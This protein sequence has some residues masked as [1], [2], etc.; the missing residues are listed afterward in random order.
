MKTRYILPVILLSVLISCQTEVEYTGEITEPKLVVFARTDISSAVQSHICYVQHS[1]FFLEDEPVEGSFL[2]DA[3]VEWQLNDGAFHPFAFV[4]D[5]CAYLPS[6]SLPGAAAG[7][8]VTFRVSHP[9]YGTT[10]ATQ[11]IPCLP[12]VRTENICIET[13]TDTLYDYS[14]QT[15]DSLVSVVYAWQK[16]SLDL[17]FPAFAT[18]DDDVAEISACMVYHS[19]ED[20]VYCLNAYLDGTDPL[21]RSRTDEMDMG[22]IDDLSSLFG[23]GK[24]R[25][26]A[27]YFPVS[28]VRQGKKAAV[29]VFTPSD[30]ELP[31]SLLLTVRVMTHDAWLYRT[32]IG[33]QSSSGSVLGLGQEEKVQVYGNFSEDVIGVFIASAEEIHAVRINESNDSISL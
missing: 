29:T 18:G 7:D 24:S 6:S 26:E 3:V 1:T 30:T 32:T 17:V 12:S 23:D 19:E 4:P 28:A 15:E 20:S 9:L 27:L 8:L 21:F 14:R 25:Y 22:I 11:T 16:I 13:A 10:S 33:K 31:D 5:N 2:N